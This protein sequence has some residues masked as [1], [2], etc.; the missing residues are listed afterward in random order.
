[1]R[2][3]GVIAR[4][5]FKELL[6]NR[7]LYAFAFFAAFLMLM[8][9]ALGQLSYTEQMRLTLGM[10]LSSIHFCL[11]GLTIFIGGSIVYREIDRLTILTLLARSIQRHEFLLGKYFGFLALMFLFTA[12]FYVL[13]CANLMLM[14]FDVSPLDI[15]VVFFGYALEIMVVLSVTIFFST[16]C[17]SFLTIIF[18]LCF[19][20]I[21][22][23]APSLTA[24]ADET[25][26]N[27]GFFKFAG[28]M[29]RILPNLENFNWR[30][31]PLEHHLTVAHLG[32]MSVVTF[33]WCLFF[34]FSATLIFR[35]KD[36]A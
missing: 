14:G 3:I 34:L 8:M 10:G 19:F 21:A 9:V 32:W 20:V 4:N 15:L 17:A 2:K 13:Y 16:F 36:F 22:H 29:R 5:T 26:F 25:T 6:R 7:V 35:N 12:G 33:S 31:Y 28:L 30:T 11:I 27:Q 1:M 23:W 24:L 18:S